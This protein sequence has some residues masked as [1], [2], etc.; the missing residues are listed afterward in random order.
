MLNFGSTE[1]VQIVG[2]LRSDI[3]S[4]IIKW[5]NKCGNTPVF[6]QPANGV[7]IP[8]ASLGLYLY[9]DNFVKTSKVVDGRIES[10]CRRT[11]GMKE[12]LM[13]VQ[14]GSSTYTS[15]GNPNLIPNSC[16]RRW[17]GINNC[18]HQLNTSH[19]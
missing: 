19:K 17:E 8:P 5:S 18:Y 4:Q 15:V 14:L 13:S 1:P 3:T 9:C 7:A 6:K 11:G 10:V 16:A 12:K 2:L